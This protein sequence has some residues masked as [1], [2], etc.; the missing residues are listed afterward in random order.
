[1]EIPKFKFL[2]FVLEIVE[3]SMT[4]KSHLSLFNMEYGRD[5]RIWASDTL[6]R[7]SVA[8]PLDVVTGI[9]PSFSTSFYTPPGIP[10]G[11]DLINIIESG[12]EDILD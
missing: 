1:M 6:T 5:V 2:I 3:F 8:S 4:V 10:A 7:M 12:G 11:I 9:S